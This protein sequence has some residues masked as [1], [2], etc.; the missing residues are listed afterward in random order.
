MNSDRSDFV[1][2]AGI[3][4]PGPEISSMYAFGLAIN[5]F[6]KTYH[7]IVKPG[8]KH[9]ILVSRKTAVNLM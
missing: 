2:V 6:E 9:L 1:S 7:F 4:R 8:T 5:L 3:L